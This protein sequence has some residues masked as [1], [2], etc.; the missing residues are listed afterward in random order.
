M[1]AITYTGI[2]TNA[3]EHIIAE[4]IA[5]VLSCPP[6]SALTHPHVRIVR[7]ENNK[8]IRK[9]ILDV[10][11]DLALTTASD[12]Q[13]WVVIFQADTM[14]KEAANAL[15]KLLEEPPPRSTFLLTARSA[16]NLLPTIRSRTAIRTVKPAAENYEPSIL[17]EA[18]TVG[19]RLSLITMLHEAQSLATAYHD[20]V[21]SLRHEK[22]F[23]EL[24]WLTHYDQYVQ[25]VPNY[26]LLLEA[27]A[28]HAAQEGRA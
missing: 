4:H 16:A 17:V 22:R 20:L 21:L 9:Q 3:V 24:K 12:Q 19:E 1:H 10:V 6:D 25:N 14:N 26:R 2:N 28:V 5:D 13:R 8:I 11:S 7:P 18:K 27:W 23:A 15:L